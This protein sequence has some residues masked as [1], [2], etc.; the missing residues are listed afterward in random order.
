MG[1]PCNDP[2][3]WGVRDAPVERMT[4]LTD[5]SRPLA[6][7]LRGGEFDRIDLSFFNRHQP[8]IKK[9]SMLIMGLVMEG[10]RDVFPSVSFHACIDAG[11]FQVRGDHEG[12]PC[13]PWFDLVY[14]HEE[15][16]RCSSGPTH[17]NLSYMHGDEVAQWGRFFIG[18]FAAVRQLLGEPLDLQEP[19]HRSYCQRTSEMFKWRELYTYW[20]W[21]YVD[22]VGEHHDPVHYSLCLEAV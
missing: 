8:D 3:T 2:S 17:I 16:P 22:K 7:A 5:R 11:C 4:W 19:T 9:I 21:G 14:T 13:S 1:L 18:A 12:N 6:R 10:V 20:P 15:L